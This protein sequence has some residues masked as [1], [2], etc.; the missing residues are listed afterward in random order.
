M[1]QNPNL[2]SP[3]RGARQPSVGPG[4]ASPKGYFG[5]AHNFQSFFVDRPANNEERTT[6]NVSRRYLITT[7]FPV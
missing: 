7:N 3:A 2:N 5:L 6:T 4:C 1:W